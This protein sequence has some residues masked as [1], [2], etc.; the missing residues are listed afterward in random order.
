[1]TAIATA[2]VGYGF[3]ARTF[4]LPF[5]QANA[6]FRLTAISTGQGARAAAELPGVAV[7]AEAEA[8]ID[9]CDAELVIITAPNAVHFALAQRALQRGRHVVLEKPFVT[10]VAAGEHLIALAGRQER[11]LSV[12]HNRRWDGDFLTL[13]RLLADKRLGEIHRF[14][15]HFDRFRPQVRQRWREQ[16]GVGSGIWFDLGPHLVDQ[17]LQLFGPPEAVT[18]RCRALR[19][20]SRVTDYFHVQLHYPALEV[21]LHSSPYCAGPNLRFDLQGSAGS[22]RKFG[23]DP[24]EARLL[25]GTPPTTERWAQETPEGFG[26]LYRGDASERIPTRCGGYQHYYR[27]LARALRGAGPNPVAA[28]EALAVIRLLQ[29]ARASSRQGRTLAV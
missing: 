12:Y 1:M 19:D 8:L 29:L 20:G 15:S 26:T 3:S 27:Q 4:H 11:L 7:F 24:Q 13:T 18:G 28:S 5:L 21:T 6:D 14:E 9:R 16:P 10:D 17:A 2:L 23:L 25:A 22:Y